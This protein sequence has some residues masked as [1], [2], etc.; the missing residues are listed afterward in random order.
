MTDQRTRS[1]KGYWRESIS[2][3][4]VDCGRSNP[5]R[6]ASEQGYSLDALCRQLPQA[7]GPVLRREGAYESLYIAFYC[8]LCCAALESAL[9]RCRVQR[10]LAGLLSARG[11][12]CAGWRSAPG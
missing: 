7:Y 2:W 6:S 11:L 1:A 4:R 3:T 8:S 10:G 5:A 12:L 9:G